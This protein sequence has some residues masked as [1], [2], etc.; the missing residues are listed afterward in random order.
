[1]RERIR[2]LGGGLEIGPQRVGGGMTV[3]ARMPIAGS[4]WSGHLRNVNTD[5]MAGG[6]GMPLRQRVHLT[7]DLVRLVLG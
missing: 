7:G 4:S 2:Q 1:M 6:R 3:V 5:V